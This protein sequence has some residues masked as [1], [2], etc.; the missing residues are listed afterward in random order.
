MVQIPDHNLRPEHQTISVL[1]DDGINLA[2]SAHKATLSLGLA[3]GLDDRH[4]HESEHGH[5][6]LSLLF[7]DV[8]CSLLLLEGLGEVADLLGLLF[9]LRG[10]LLD[11]SSP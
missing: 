4:A 5:D 2:I 3:W 9:L 7:G 10:L 6:V 8:G 11:L 1:C